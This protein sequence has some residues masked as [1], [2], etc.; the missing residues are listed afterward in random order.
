[1]STRSPDL[2]SAK[3]SR[4]ALPRILLR[5]ACLSRLKAARA[6]KIIYIS[7]LAGLGKTTLAL[8]WLKQTR[9]KAVWL[10]LDEQDNDPAGF[11][12][13]L[14][15][16]FAVAFPQTQLTLPSLPTAGPFDPVMFARSYCQKLF[17]QVSGR[18][19][20][21]LDDCH[22]IPEDNALLFSIIEVVISHAPPSVQ[23][24]LLSRNA[25]PTFLAGW[26]GKRALFHLDQEALRFSTEEVQSLFNE[27]LEVPI[28]PDQAVDLHRTT[29]GWVTGLILLKDRVRRAGRAIVVEGMPASLADDRLADYFYHGVYGRLDPTTKDLM[30]RCSVFESFG[31]KDAGLMSP[32][33]DIAS[34]MRFLVRQHLLSE[35][36]SKEATQFRYHPLL[37][38]FLQDRVR[39]LPSEEQ[40]HL[41]EQVAAVLLA[42]GQA[43]K[44]VDLYLAAGQ[45]ASAMGLIEQ[46]GLGAVFQGKRMKLRQWIRSIPPTQ[47]EGR[48]WLVYLLGAGR[49]FEAPQEAEACYQR[50]LQGFETTG[51]VEGQLW[52]LGSL[53]FVGFYRAH[54]YRPMKK[55]AQQGRRLLKKFPDSCSPMARASFLFANGLSAI[56]AEAKP[57]LGLRSSLAAADLAHQNGLFP[58]YIMAMSYAANAALHSGRLQVAKLSLAKV[59]D[60]GL[61]EHLDPVIAAQPI[62]FRGLLESFQGEAEQALASMTALESFCREH[63]LLTML[64]AVQSNLVHHR[65]K[66]GLGHTEAVSSIE[67][68]QQQAI[69]AGNR[70]FG[71]FTF[72]TQAVHLLSV[73]KISQ[74]LIHAEESV[75]LLKACGAPLFL[76][77]CVY[78]QGVILGEMGET[79]KAERNLL[80]ALRGLEK[81]KSNFYTFWVLLQLAKVALDQHN[82]KKAKTYLARALKLGKTEEYKEADG[83]L[84]RTK[85]ILVTR[86]LEWNLEPPYVQ[87]LMA[88][89]K[90]TPTIALKI[91][92]LGRFEV[93]LHDQPVP[94]EAWKGRKTLQL[95]LALL[96]LGGKQVPKSRISDLL[97]PEAE[98]D[99]GVTNFHTTLHRLQAVLDGSRN[100]GTGIITLTGGSVSVNPAQCWSDCCAFDDAVQQARQAERRGRWSEGKQH[101]ESARAL[102]QG[103]YLPGFEEAW[104]VSRREALQ[105]Q[106][107]WVEQR[108]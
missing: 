83:L 70:L 84:P 69:R 1:M 87:R 32:S 71:G 26:I 5:E 99:R 46:I 47:V 15:E 75:R 12:R 105:R 103:E 74:A 49:E 3:A 39:E 42:K 22:S 108:L 66:M 36:P 28:T 44:A 60:P 100:N 58:L 92:T 29:E 77:L 27:V 33:S 21:V 81:A 101:L 35:I 106:W 34:R 52:T 64:P 38:K 14:A 43:D 16:A 73:G 72:F 40:Q 95:L 30:V 13:L 80:T 88:H 54:D 9:T 68:I 8:S 31:M 23:V 24:V 20:L 98:G 78:I 25:P 94:P 6:Y 4:P 50:A 7:G 56:Y 63:G 48:P 76:N 89:W 91:H 17:S 62:C 67:A 97:W 57:H 65:I 79:G 41:V 18:Y 19:A 107:L 10:T 96:A 86:A 45:Y 85:S 82:E 90:V 59:E 55:Y 93:R 61:Q 51:N 102:Y 37:R 53:I 11:L 104:I 2:G